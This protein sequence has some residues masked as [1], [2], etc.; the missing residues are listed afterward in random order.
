MIGD[1]QGPLFWER[2]FRE[3][4][5]SETAK[6]V[7]Q[8]GREAPQATVLLGD[9]VHWGSSRSSWKYFDELMRRVGG[10]L[11]PVR[12]NHDYWGNPASAENAW[13]RRF[14]WFE[15]EPWYWVKW[16]HVALVFVDSNFGRLEPAARCA[17]QQWYE[18][19]LVDLNKHREI[20]GIVVFLHH[21]PYTGNPNAQDDLD[22]LRNAFVTPFCR[23]DKALA[24]IAG[25][26]H[27]YERYSQ[28]C[29]PR[30]VQFIV[31]GGGGGPRPG[32][33]C[34]AYHDECLVSGCCEPRSRPLH[35]LLL[36]QHDEGID[37]TARPLAADGGLGMLDFVRIPFNGP[38]ANLSPESKVC[39]RWR[40]AH[41]PNNITPPRFRDGVIGIVR[42][43]D[44]A[45][46]Q[47]VSRNA[48]ACYGLKRLAG[49]TTTFV[50]PPAARRWLGYW[51]AQYQPSRPDLHRRHGRAD[52]GR[53]LHRLGGWG[54][55][56]APWPQAGVTKGRLGTGQDHVRS[57]VQELIEQVQ[58]SLIATRAARGVRAALV[59]D[60]AN[61]AGYGLSAAGQVGQMTG[62][63]SSTSV[64]PASRAHRA[65]KTRIAVVGIGGRAE[66]ELESDHRVAGWHRLQCDERT[67]EQDEISRSATDG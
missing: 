18:R 30:T 47:T 8:L 16:N 26:A 40:G 59:G 2:F 49:N 42:G 62:C 60:V 54:R 15:H 36:G 11:L 1:L 12:G 46:G 20:E 19:T 31:S 63:C 6:L 28:T 25:H 66:T 45:T 38:S 33:V 34:P 67:S 17:E 37:I 13:V 44:V 29:G 53:F 21:A 24:M 27:G 7:C 58:G 64:L 35:Y 56:A 41:R 61:R 4:N 50:A 23:L 55:R 14:P 43:G 48:G 32:L 5:S 57:P 9:L 52:R 39:D 51:L 3:D 22:A 65:G 10:V